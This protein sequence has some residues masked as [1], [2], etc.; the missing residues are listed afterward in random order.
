ML[1]VADLTPKATTN[2][3]TGVHIH[4]PESSTGGGSAAGCSIDSTGG[5]TECSITGWTEGRNT[6][7]M[8]FDYI[9]Y[10]LARSS[11]KCWLLDRAT[12]PKGASTVAKQ[13]LRSINLMVQVI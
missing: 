10:R 1:K 5:S 12:S 9:Q 11:F 4:P 6:R 8:A 7:G 3:H 13:L 2:K